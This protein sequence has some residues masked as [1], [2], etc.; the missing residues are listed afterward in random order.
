MLAISRQKV[1]AGY[2]I[3]WNQALNLI[4]N[5]HRIERAQPRLKSVRFEPDCMTICLARL[6]S[7]GLSHVRSLATA[8]R[9]QLANIKSHG[10][11][12][13]D[14]HFEIRLGTCDFT[15]LLNELQIPA[16]VVERADL[17][18]SVRGWQYYIRDHCGLGQEHVL[19]NHEAVRKCEGVNAQAA[20]GI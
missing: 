4:Q 15:G 19:H 9:D 16:G 20:H 14:N 8:E 7:A 17:L 12:N 5:R 11:G 13:A 1:H 2:V 10:V 6:S 3:A 18:I